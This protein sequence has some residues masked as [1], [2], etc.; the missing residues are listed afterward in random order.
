MPL[1]RLKYDESHWT[2][3]GD[4]EKG[5]EQYLE[6]AGRAFNRTKSDLFKRLLGDVNGKKIL[7]YGGGAGIMS[8]PMAEDGAHVVM[9]DAEANALHTARRYAEKRL[10]ADS[11]RIIHSE[12]LPESLKKERFDVIIAKDVVEHIED[13]QKFLKDLARCQKK[14][15]VMLLSTQS[16]TSLN[17][18][19]E[20]GYQKYWRKN[21][22][23]RGWDQT[24]LRFY[25]PALLKE[26]LR[27][28]GYKPVKWAGVYILP[29][30]ILS[31]F[32]LCKINITIPRLRHFDLLLG[33]RFPFNRLGWNVIVRAEKTA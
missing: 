16:K 7:D 3:E 14:G 22:K 8:I 5:L 30:N 12:C 6:L 26:R 20:G 28:A 33:R 15:G 2:R 19:L 1:K 4:V 11:I 24:H 29:Y 13:D 18:L 21:S 31:W 25:T 17:Y 27:N 23:W 32:S 9:V 10:V